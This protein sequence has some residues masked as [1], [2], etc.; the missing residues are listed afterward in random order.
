MV[1]ARHLSVQGVKGCWGVK[2]GLSERIQTYLCMT[3]YALKIFFLAL[4]FLV[5]ILESYVFP[6]FQYGT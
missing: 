1:V 5:E 4:Y 6:G 2:M 3:N